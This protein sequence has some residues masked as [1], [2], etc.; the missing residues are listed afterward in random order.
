MKNKKTIIIVLIAIFLSSVLTFLVS[1]KWH[2]TIKRLRNSYVE[3]REVSFINENI[4]DI[5]KL[6]T[7]KD[8]PDAWYTKYH[9]VSHA[10]G[11]ING[12]L[13]S[14]SLE[15]WN[16]SYENG[17]RVFDADLML[18]TDGQVI[19][20]HENNDNL[21]LN[22]NIIS[23]SVFSIT[24]TGCLEITTDDYPLTFEEFMN[25]KIY[26]K[27]TPISLENMIDYMYEHKDLYISVD[28]K[29]GIKK[30]YKKLYDT[31]VAKD[32]VEILDRII[33]NI[34]NKK[35]YKDLKKI[36]NFK[37]YN[38]RQYI[39][40]PQNY[41]ELAK[42]CVKNDIHVINISKKFITADEIKVLSEKGIHVYVAVIDYLSD[43]NYYKD[44][45][46]TGVITNWLYENDWEINR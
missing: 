16:L 17:N 41:Y 45:G 30:I 46:A 28:A 36:Y 19:L 42:F 40:N 12:K 9:F 21:E 7:L 44:K 13:Y 37:N 11:G 6:K 25:S 10:G 27:F 29:D 35:L 22:E 20:R 18:T 1:Y 3:K 23:K 31:A 38:V 33:V 2:D 32:K 26:G 14:N 5:K 39:N 8:E 24:D 15:A 43:L 4:N 34:Y